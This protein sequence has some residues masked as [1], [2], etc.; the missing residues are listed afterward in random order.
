MTREVL[1][2]IAPALRAAGFSVG[3]TRAAA[4][5]LLVRAAPA[6][7]HRVKALALIERGLELA[8]EKAPP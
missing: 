6:L 1:R 7:G 2:K 5:P 8:G 4:T 3:T